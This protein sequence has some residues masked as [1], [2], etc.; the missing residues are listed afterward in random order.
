[1]AEAVRD[2]RKPYAERKREIERTRERRAK[3]DFRE[4]LAAACAVKKHGRYEFRFTLRGSSTH[5]PIKKLRLR[6]SRSSRVYRSS[7]VR[8]S[9]IVIVAVVF[10][11]QTSLSCDFRLVL[12][13]EKKRDERNR[14]KKRSAA[15][16]TRTGGGGNR[17]VRES[18][19]KMK[20]RRIHGEIEKIILPHV[21]RRR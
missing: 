5:C 9:V 7:T 2:R 4:I 21:M 17:T 10:V 18:V 11:A 12:F 1:M 16:S 3:G 15:A 14:R 13:R 20:I 8:D 6:G 19:K